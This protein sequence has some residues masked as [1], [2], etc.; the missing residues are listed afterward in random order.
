MGA[1]NVVLAGPRRVGK[2]SVAREAL[3]ACLHADAYTVAVDLFR[4]PEAL[5]LAARSIRRTGP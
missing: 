2:T 1:I 5:A 4:Q 3:E